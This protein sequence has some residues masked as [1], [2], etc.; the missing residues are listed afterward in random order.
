MVQFFLWKFVRF[1]EQEATCINHTEVP[2]YLYFIWMTQMCLKISIVI[3]KWTCNALFRLFLSTEIDYFSLSYLNIKNIYI[4]VKLVKNQITELFVFCSDSESE[5]LLPGPS[6]H[7]ENEPL[8]SG[9]GRGRQRMEERARDSMSCAHG[10]P[11]NCLRK[12]NY[13]SVAC[14]GK[15]IIFIFSLVFV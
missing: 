7:S 12:N 9:R 15:L 3:L 14:K 11:H 10:R 2:I 13:R 8:L 6:G 1:L 5:S 4:Y